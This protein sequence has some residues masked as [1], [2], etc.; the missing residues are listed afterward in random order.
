MRLLGDGRG[1]KDRGGGLGRLGLVRWRSG[2]FGE[3][4]GVLLDGCRDELVV[5]EVEVR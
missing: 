3:R 2:L 5:G 4:G 1:M